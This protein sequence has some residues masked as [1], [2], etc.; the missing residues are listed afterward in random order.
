MAKARAPN[1]GGPVLPLDM[2]ARTTWMSQQ[3]ELK[4][5]ILTVLALFS[6][7]S[8]LIYHALLIIALF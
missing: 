3:A 5:S 4:V 7:A 1:E 2:T 6:F 8:L